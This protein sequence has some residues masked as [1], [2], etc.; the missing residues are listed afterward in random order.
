MPAG[1]S[2]FMLPLCPSSAGIKAFQALYERHYG[3]RLSYTG[4]EV[5]LTALLGLLDAARSAAVPDCAGA[6]QLATRGS[7]GNNPVTI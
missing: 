7:R 5:K 2:F 1:G 4:A 3:V 6:A